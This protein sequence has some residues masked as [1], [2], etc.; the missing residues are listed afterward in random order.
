MDLSSE[1]LQNHAVAP[2][3]T[4]GSAFRSHHEKRSRMIQWGM[5]R[6]NGMEAAGLPDQ[7]T[8]AGD[9]SFS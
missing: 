4:T 1:T 5:E 9:N 7:L 8:S 6:G 2:A 3:N